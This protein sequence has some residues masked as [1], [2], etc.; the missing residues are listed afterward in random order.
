[1]NITNS[2][3]V[4]RLYN[5]TNKFCDLLVTQVPQEDVY[6]L[7][8][9]ILF[10]KWIFDSKERYDWHVSYEAENLDQALLNSE[11]YS[12]DLYRLA[13]EI[14]T[15]NPVFN[16]ILTTLCFAHIN[17]IKPELL[18]EMCKQYREVNFKN[19]NSEKKIT[20][21]FIEKFLQNLTNYST[22]YSFITPKPVKE[23]LAKIFPIYEG[24]FL[25]DITAGTCGILTEIVN[26]SSNEGLGNDKI[27]LYGQEINYK[28]ALIGKLNLLLHG[29]RNPNVMIKDSLK[30]TILKDRKTLDKIDIIVSNLPLGLNWNENEIAYREEFKYEYPSK[31]FADWLF[32]QRSLA[33]LSDNG[34]A[35]FVVSKGTLT[36][37]SE[38]SIRK[39]F[40]LE[41]LIEA[42][43]SLPN[44]LYGSK[45]MAIEILIINKSKVFEKK[46]KILF[47][48]ASKEY[49]KKER[50]KNDLT[51]EHIDKILDAFHNWREIEQYSKIVDSTA[52]E[53][54][55]FELDGPLYV[56]NRVMNLELGHVKKLKDVADIRRGLQI[57]KNETNKLSIDKGKH[58]YIKISD[59]NNGEI[60]FN[61]KISGLSESK[62]SSYELRPQDI[63]ISARGTLIK[64]AIYEQNMP[65]SIISGNIM[66][67]RVKKDYNPY[68]LKFFLNSSK[69]KEMIQDMQGGSTI[70]SLN[71]SKLQD[72]LV[73]DLNRERQ[74]QLAE[75]ITANEENYKS[76][77]EHATKMYEQN[78]DIIN[79]EIFSSMNK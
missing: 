32:I 21:P 39:N 29:V 13:Q 20:G 70:T 15:N 17:Y 61:E 38:I 42:V 52:I 41:D 27:R 26:Q 63:I 6:F 14:E 43:I 48:D 77:V 45:T 3:V 57:S 75:R 40:I 36:R 34:K 35:A 31:M 33:A 11:S 59:I 49:Y 53:E 24:M 64:T 55:C 2:Y 7:P 12:E 46:N 5:I 58:Y 47:I 78:V 71:H 10:I 76:I 65:P 73:P 22:F 28:I 44:N 23:M 69:G 30:E 4:N 60:T 67:I 72:L 51:S 66:L 68:F 37:T 50:G 16:E 25:A 54:N 79:K 18:K 74:D 56:N 9:G 62:I 8:V 19:E 1:M